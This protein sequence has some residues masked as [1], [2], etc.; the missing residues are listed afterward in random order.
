VR[1]AQA[2]R[3]A[4]ESAFKDQANQLAAQLQMA[5]YRF[6][7]AE[8]RVNLY[9]AT[10]LPQARNAFNVARQSYETGSADFLNLIDAQRILLEFEL[11]H[12][13]T[14]TKR[15]QARATVEMLVGRSLTHADASASE[16]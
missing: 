14:L 5:L 12:Q 10:L 7:D 1:E 4:A 9:V 8:R 6:H 11:E 3:D 15:E 16:D 2:R 13:R